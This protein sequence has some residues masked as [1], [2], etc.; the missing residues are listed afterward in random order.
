MKFTSCLKILAATACLTAPQLAFAQASVEPTHG[1]LVRLNP[2]NFWNIADTQAEIQINEPTFLAEGLKTPTISPDGKQVILA[3]RTFNPGEKGKL[4]RWNDSKQPLEMIMEDEEVSDHITWTSNNDFFMRERSAPFFKDGQKRH[5]S[6]ENKLTRFKTRRLIQE[7]PVIAYDS[8]DVIVMKRL[9]VIQ[10]ISDV[11]VD[12]YYGPIVSA[13]ENY[14][15][16]SGLSTG[17]NLFDIAANAVVYQDNKGTSPHFSADSKY[18]IYAQTSDDGHVLTQGDIVVID[19]NAKTKRRIA[20]PKGEVRVNAT[21]S[22][23]AKF[24][25]YENVNGECFRAQVME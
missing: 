16:F 10:A 12:R 13:D 2:D 17:I 24:I 14:I 18:L 20:N 6:I 1:G 22:N 19:L 8:D 23:D 5:F 25:A 15:V 11:T 3:R 21:L 9:G 4:Y 7:N